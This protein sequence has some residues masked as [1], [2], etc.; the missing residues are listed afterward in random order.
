MMKH[1]IARIALATAIAGGS[2]AGAVP[3]SNAQNSIPN[4]TVNSGIQDMSSPQLKLSSSVGDSFGLFAM[5][6][7]GHTLSPGLW[8]AILRFTPPLATI[9][10]S[11]PAVDNGTPLVFTVTLNPPPATATPVAIASAN[12]VGAMTGVTNNCIAP[13]MVQPSG[14]GTCTISA[15]NIIPFDG[16]TNATVTLAAGA[17]WALGSPSSATGTIN[18]DDGV[19][20]VTAVTLSVIE[21]EPA[22]FNLTCRGAPTATVSY[23]FGGTYSP[24]PPNGGPTVITCG[25]PLPIAIPTI[26]DSAINGSRTITLSLADPTPFALIRGG[27]SATVTVLDVPII[28]TLNGVGLVLLGL[29]VAFVAVSTRRRRM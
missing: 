9:A 26:N 10:V 12:V 13:V 11:A 14:T 27:E 17:G 20:G 29:L 21:G 8:G 15:S 24:L 16:P 28:P 23:S 5:S 3:P 6:G 22:L 1:Y 19:V 7:V 2:A 4:S 18:D 25:I